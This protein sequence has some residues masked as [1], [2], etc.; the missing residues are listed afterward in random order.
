MSLTFLSLTL[1]GSKVQP[2]QK[3]KLLTLVHLEGDL[4][5]SLKAKVSG[6]G[7][8]KKYIYPLSLLLLYMDP[9]HRVGNSCY[10]WTQSAE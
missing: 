7:I 6:K 4:Q 5:G 2:Q 10:T 3:M 9:E 1:K 8:L